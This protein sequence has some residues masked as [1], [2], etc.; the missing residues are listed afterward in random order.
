MTS[1][2]QLVTSMLTMIADIDKRY[3]ENHEIISRTDKETQ[4]LL[5]E[6]EF[7]KFNGV[8]GYWLAKKLQEVRQDRRKAK[9]ENEQLWYLY[10]DVFGNNPAFKNALTN[11]HRNI[12]RKEQEQ[13]ER[14]Y[15]PR[16]RDDL[17]ICG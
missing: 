17:T 1:P 9:N 13:D 8:Q 3:N 4:D 5:H 14:S 11:A 10:K 16:V 15:T 12:K 7:A 2:E 6:I